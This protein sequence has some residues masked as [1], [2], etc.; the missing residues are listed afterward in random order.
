MD[1][2]AFIFHAFTLHSQPEMDGGLRDYDW[3][4]ITQAALWQST[5]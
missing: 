2:T 4:Q 5:D 3:P 1:F